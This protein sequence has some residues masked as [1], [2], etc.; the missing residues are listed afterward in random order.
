MTFI[1]IR[2]ILSFYILTL[3]SLYAVRVRFLMQWLYLTT[4]RI[5]PKLK[6]FFATAYASHCYLIN[7][8]MRD[9]VAVELLPLTMESS[10]IA[11][12]VLMP[13]GRSKG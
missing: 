13:I 11:L 1:F 4:P 12:L 8:P 2:K 5:I 9:F 7:V 3:S 10:T 6:T